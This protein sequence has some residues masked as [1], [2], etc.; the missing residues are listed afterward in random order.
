[1]VRGWLSIRTKIFGGFLIVLAV[2]GALGISSVPGLDKI[3]HV[4]REVEITGRVAQAA[5]AYDAALMIAGALLKQAAL[6]QNELEIDAAEHA[7]KALTPALMQLRRAVTEHDN[8]GRLAEIAVRQDGYLSRFTAMIDLIR[9]RRDN[10]N[11]IK[12]SVPNLRR[13]IEA[14]IERGIPPDRYEARSIATQLERK[15]FDT[16]DYGYRYAISRDPAESEAIF[17]NI[18]NFKLQLNEIQSLIMDLPIALRIR[19]ELVDKLPNLI[20]NIDG[21]V[22]ST[23]KLPDIDRE[24]IASTARLTADIGELRASYFAGQ[25]T[26]VSVISETIRE[27]RR[28]NIL[29]PLIALIFSIIIASFVGISISRLILRMAGAI[30]SLASGNTEVEVP[31]LDRRDEIGR[32]AAAVQ[33]FKENAIA[34][35][36]SEARYRELLENL[37]EGVYQTTLDGHLLSVNHAFAIMLGYESVDSLMKAVTDI[38]QQ[39]YVNPKDR[40]RLLKDLEHRG[41]VHGYEVQMKCRDNRI[42]TIS[43]SARIVR[44]NGVS[45]RIEGTLAD[46]TARREAE[47]R[48]RALNSELE[49]RERRRTGALETALRSLQQA[50]DELV[51]SEKLAG[52][53]A[54]VAG[55]AHEVNTPIG[56]SVTVATSLQQKAA[57]FVA[58]VEQGGLRR[59]T[60]RSFLEDMTQAS[61][62]ILHSLQQASTLVSNFKQVAVDQ[63]SER[64]RCFDCR[65]VTAEVMSTL[66]PMVKRRKITIDLDIPAG[67]I[68]DGFP[69]A[70]GQVITNLVTNA[71]I[72]GF[73]SRDIGLLRIIGTKGIDAQD[74]AV[75]QLTITDDGNGIPIEI[76]SKIFDP[77]FT[78]KM[79]TGG[80]GL[81]LHLVYSIVTR[82]LGGR[83]NVVSNAG[84]GA[85][86]SL[87]LPMVAPSR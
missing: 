28:L 39:L 41:R 65:I 82:I 51:R 26:A 45:I 42:I 48:I 85:C 33:A 10:T 77:F 31:A 71:F 12:N 78:T 5:Q 6:T 35:I 73:E 16:V 9:R 32:M 74:A 69:G 81:G 22:E 7:A 3:E 59:S 52:L 25:S 36:A 76:Q 4:L 60:L 21:L 50:Q 61:N 8:Q 58:T 20:V 2:I 29:L 55:I 11:D 67:I 68:I 70:Y 57:C 62:M 18:D 47:D 43:C 84:E 80:S 30:T 24:F 63:T 83:I 27:I 56:T 17:R 23:G 79:G 49:D 15:L 37:V 86:F 87:T 38:S 1:M 34:L 64:R 72:H 75:I 66:R 40:E 19:S 13:I 44:E 46:I 14:L 54:L 53:G